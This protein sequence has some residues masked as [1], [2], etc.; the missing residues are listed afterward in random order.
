MRVIGRE[1]LG[2]VDPLVGGRSEKQDLL[3]PGAEGIGDGVAN[4]P[5]AAHGDFVVKAEGHRDD[6]C[7]LLFG[8]PFY[9]LRACGVSETGG[10]LL[11]LERRRGLPS[12]RFRS[13]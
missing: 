4:H 7:L 8:C 3:I 1:H 10:G 5:L 2:L 9:C 12:Q 11:W 13:S 6:V